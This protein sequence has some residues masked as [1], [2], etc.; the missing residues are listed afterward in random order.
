MGATPSAPSLASCGPQLPAEGFP[1]M[2]LNLPVTDPPC[3]K[4]FHRPLPRSSTPKQSHLMVHVVGDQAELNS[5]SQAEPT[6][7]YK[8]DPSQCP[9]PLPR[10]THLGPGHTVRVRGHPEPVCSLQTLCT[11]PRPGNTKKSSSTSHSTL[12]M[13]LFQGLLKIS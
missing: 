4:P 1:P 8:P 2:Q 11:P 3:T 7:P 6:P 13:V 5:P 10:L 12:H 9:P